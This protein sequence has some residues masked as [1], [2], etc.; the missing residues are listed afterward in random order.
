MKLYSKD[1]GEY[2]KS[3]AVA[4]MFDASPFIYSG[5]L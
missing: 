2:N 3:D 4:E 1:L 5:Q